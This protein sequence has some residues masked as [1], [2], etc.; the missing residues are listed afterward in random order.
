MALR[1]V[2]PVALV[3]NVRSNDVVAGADLSVTIATADTFQIV[4]PLRTEDLLV[5]ISFAGTTVVTF[6]AGPNPPSLRSPLGAITISGVNAEVRLVLL[7]GGRFIQAGSSG[8]SITGSNLGANCK[9]AAYRIAR[10]G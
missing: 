10:T 2:T 4:T 1:T 9:M 3:A 8:M 7:E 6:N 5:V